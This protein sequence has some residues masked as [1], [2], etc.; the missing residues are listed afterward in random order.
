MPARTKFDVNSRCGKFNNERSRDSSYRSSTGNSSHGLL[1][2]V[3][4]PK[5][6][7]TTEHK[8]YDP[9]ALRGRGSIFFF[10]ILNLP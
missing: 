10:L 5:T 9:S 6:V 3:A 2:L 1:L 4:D 7:A 8:E